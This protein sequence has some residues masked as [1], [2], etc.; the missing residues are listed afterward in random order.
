MLAASATVCGQRGRAA[1]LARVRAPRTC[2]H[3]SAGLTV[4]SD[5]FA[6]RELFG[7]LFRR[8]LQA[9]Y[10]GSALGVV[11]VAPE[12]AR[13]SWASTCSSSR[14]SGAR[15]TSRTTR[16]T[17]SPASRPGSSS[18]PRCRPAAGSMLDNAPLIRKT[19]FPRQLVAFSVVGTHLVTFVVMLAILMVAL[20]RVRARSRATRSGSRCRS[21]RS[22]SASSP[23]SRLRVASLERALP[24]RRAPGRFAAPAVV[25]PDADPLFVRRSSSH[26]T[27]TKVLRYAN[28]DHAAD[29]GDPR[30]AAGPGQ[31]PRLGDV[32]YLVVAAAVALAL[33]AFVF[34]RVDDRIAVEL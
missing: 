8:D 7:N 34:R 12:P 11:W 9:K 10:Q 18:R 26:D 5:L 14:S 20:L 17:C 30:S 2:L 31:V 1:L 23:A 22:S 27:L 29:R 21:R 16:S 6:Y 19:R 4:Y 25:L 33:G 15:A 32:V 24:R 3:Y 13:C 28:S